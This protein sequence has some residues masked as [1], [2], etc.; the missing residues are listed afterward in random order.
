MY[1]AALL[2][3]SIN[4][5]LH[6]LD[7]V[8]EQEMPGYKDLACSKYT[9]THIHFRKRTIVFCSVQTRNKLLVQISASTA[10][11]SRRGG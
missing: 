7:L 2:F 10:P 8:L 11:S 6:I 9:H 5:F 4:F 1:C 3:I